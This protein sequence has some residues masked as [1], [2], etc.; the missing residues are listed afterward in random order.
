VLKIFTA[1]LLM[2]A[3]IASP[4]HAEE[5]YKRVDENGVPSFS[6]TKSKDAEKIIVEPVNVQKIPPLTEQPRSYSTPTEPAF[7]YSKLKITSPADQTTL[8]NEHSIVVQAAVTPGLRSGH[9]IEFLDNGQPLQA[10]GKKTSIELLDFE[11][12]SHSLSVRILDN[13]GKVVIT[14]NPV[15]LHIFRAVIKPQPA[16]P[17]KAP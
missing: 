5:V 17:A 11:R 13:Q 2:C 4:T 3:F 6:D 10:G 15:T 7:Q 14:S 8:R 1:A 12:G 16:P 9:T